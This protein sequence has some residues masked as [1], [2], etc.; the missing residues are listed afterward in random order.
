MLIGS[1]QVLMQNACSQVGSTLYRWA[2]LIMLIG[3]S[4]VECM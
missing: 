3:S 4:Q 2:F 1:S